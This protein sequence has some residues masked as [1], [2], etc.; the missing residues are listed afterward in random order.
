MHQAMQDL[1]ALTLL[2]QQIGREKT[3]ALLEQDGELTLTAFPCSA[4]RFEA[5]RARINRAIEESL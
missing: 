2:E 4:A 5:L 3:L 1:R